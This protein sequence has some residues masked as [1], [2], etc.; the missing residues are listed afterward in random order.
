MR[1]LFTHHEFKINEKAF[2]L[3]LFGDIHFGTT[4]FDEDRFDWFL[5]RAADSPN[6][7]Y[8]GMGDYTD[9]ASM[10]E[11]KKLK[12]M[13]LHDTTNEKLDNM[14]ISDNKLIADKCKQMRG[15]LIGLIGGNH[16]FLLTSGKL[17]D[18]D[19][20]ER[21]GTAYLGW[22]SIISLAFPS[23]KHSGTRCNIFACHGKGGGKL[24]G[25]SINAI[26]D[27]TK[28]INNADIYC[29]GHDHQRSATPKT[30]LSLSTNSGL[31][32]KQKR[33]FLV[34]SGSFQKS[35]EKDKS[36]FAQGRIM[37]PA[38]LGAVRLNIST[39]RDKNDGDKTILDIEGVI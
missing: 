34:R 17:S 11:N 21:L 33:Q 30:V 23:D 2:T 27:M 22:L 9:F 8:L 5:K 31:S 15:R 4:S 25:S 38:D 7:Y 10:S 36:G 12:A 37:R 20:S 6:P 24:I 18:E 14:A 39:H 13:D 3:W 29:M 16:Q 1:N 28:V 26:D 19:L 32:L 35:Y